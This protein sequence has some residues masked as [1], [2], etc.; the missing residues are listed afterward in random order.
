MGVGMDVDINMSTAFNVVPPR[1][2]VP[3][4]PIVYHKAEGCAIFHELLTHKMISKRVDVQCVLVRP[5]PVRKTLNSV[6]F[7][8]HATWRA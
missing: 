4:G 3:T 7:F 6:G 5:L 8:K 2:D 1:S